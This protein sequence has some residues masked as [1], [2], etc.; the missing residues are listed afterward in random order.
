MKTAAERRSAE[1]EVIGS[2]SLSGR[3]FTLP[4]CRVEDTRTAGQGPV[5]SGVAEAWPIYAACGIPS[6]ARAVSVN[7]TVIAPTGAGFLTLFA[8]DQPLPATSTINFRA[9]QVRANNAVVPLAAGGDGTLGV[10]ASVAGN[11]TVHVVLDVNGYF[12]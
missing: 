1:T 9:G 2:G 4:P 12:E 3:Y 6:T 10:F 8:G 7:L 11:G 5:A